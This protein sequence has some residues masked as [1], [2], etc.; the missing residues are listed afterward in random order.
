MS[1]EEV[2]EAFPEHRATLSIYP[3]QAT[4]KDLREHVYLPDD[5]KYMMDQLRQ[6]S[7]EQLDLTHQT[8]GPG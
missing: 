8:L 7:D 2:M 6:C 1:R 4:A 3:H 5:I